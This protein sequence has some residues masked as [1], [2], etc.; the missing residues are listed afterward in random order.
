MHGTFNQK[1]GD[2]QLKGGSLLSKSRYVT[3][4]SRFSN[5]FSQARG[6]KIKLL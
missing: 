4:E 1:N 5:L 2:V 3:Y 6:E